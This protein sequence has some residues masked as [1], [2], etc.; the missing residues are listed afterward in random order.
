MPFS[1]TIKVPLFSELSKAFMPK[2]FISY[3]RA[4]SQTIAGRIYDHLV[5]EFGD[6]NV[7]KDTFDISPGDD[8]RGTIR[9]QVAQCDV[10]LVLIGNSWLTITEANSSTPRLDNPEDWVRIEVETGLQRGN[11]RVI[12]V[13]VQNAP[14]PAP[15]QLPISLRELAFRN[16]ITV[17]EDPDFQSDVRKLATSLGSTAPKQPVTKPVPVR[18]DES[19]GM[20]KAVK[21]TLIGLASVILV[22]LIVVIVPSLL[23][24]PKVTSTVAPTDTAVL[25]T[26]VSIPLQTNPSSTFLPTLSATI[27]NASVPQ[28]LIQPVIASGSTELTLIT[29]EK[30]VVLYVPQTTNLTGFQLTAFISG[31]A[32]PILLTD[33]FDSLKLASGITPS[34]TCFVLTLEGSADRLPLACN[35]AGDDG[36]VFKH[37]LSDSDRFWYDGIRNLQR[38]LA[39]YK[40]GT[41]TGVVCPASQ[42]TCKFDWQI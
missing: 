30:S 2:I 1:D 34:D 42:P 41:A 21:F 16:S 18:Q 26:S 24:Q 33:Y 27:V 9:E 29:S 19:R 10:L 12:P 11:V 6:E 7:F 8:F 13:L 32:T 25:V 28:T 23:N 4:D 39:I 31:T 37:E 22:A 17:R 14:M 35:T 36:R 40:D 5:R 15:S 38:D 3:R 20:S